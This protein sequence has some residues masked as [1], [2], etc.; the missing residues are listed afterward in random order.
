MT[1]NDYLARRAAC[2]I[3]TSIV[4]R[5]SPRATSSKAEACGRVNLGGLGA[6]WTHLT[7]GQPFGAWTGKLMKGIRKKL[8]G[9]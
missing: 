2:W 6:V 8:L 5:A 7:T 3:G 4:S 1:V 9:A